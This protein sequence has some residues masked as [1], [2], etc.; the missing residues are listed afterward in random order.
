MDA[1]TP[2]GRY[3]RPQ[4]MAEEYITRQWAYPV[5]Y[6]MDLGKA[7]RGDAGERRRFD[8]FLGSLNRRPKALITDSQAMDLM[9]TWTPDEVMLTTF[10]IMMINYV[11]RGRLARFAEGIKALDISRLATRS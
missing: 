2:P 5:S 11:S 10:S 7:R 4:A 1:E 8:A 6:R 9:H 3:L